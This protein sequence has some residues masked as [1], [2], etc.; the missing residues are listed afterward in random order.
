MDDYTM[1]IILLLL[2]AFVTMTFPLVVSFLTVN[3]KKIKE[4]EITV[5]FLKVIKAHIKLNNRSESE[6]KK[7]KTKRTKHNK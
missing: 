5:S 7:P 6:D 3:S 4:V 1:Q 2:L